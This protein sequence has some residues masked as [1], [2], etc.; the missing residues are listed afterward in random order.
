METNIIFMSNGLQVKNRIT[1]FLENAIYV[2]VCAHAYIN[3]DMYLDSRYCLFF[4]S[5]P[6]LAA[7]LTLAGNWLFF[8]EN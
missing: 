5:F 4:G 7:S 3:V 6:T 8:L 1:Y 2:Y